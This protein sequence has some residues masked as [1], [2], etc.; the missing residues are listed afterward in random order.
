MKK[1]MNKGLTILSNKLLKYLYTN[2][3]S[4][5]LRSIRIPRNFQFVLRYE[6]LT[7]AT[8]FKKQNKI[9]VYKNI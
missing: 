5:K 8:L 9:S 3:N 7:Q 1:V 2:N 4:K 6:D